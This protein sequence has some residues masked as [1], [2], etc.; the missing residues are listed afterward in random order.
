MKAA[1]LLYGNDQHY[2]DHLAPLASF[3]QIPLITTEE[4]IQ[5]QLSTYYPD[6]EGIFWDYLDVHFS[7]VNRFDTIFY[8]FTREHFEES[9]AF[10][11]DHFQKKI[12]TVWCPHGNSDKNNLGALQG[13][14]FLLTYGKKMDDLLK[15]KKIKKPKFS[16]GNYR[17]AYYQKH[18]KFYQD[19]LEKELS[20]LPR[21]NP[22]FLYAPTWQ[23][24]ENSSSFD[25]AFPYLL[26][27]LPDSVNLLIKLHPN[28]WAKYPFEVERAFYPYE[29]KKNLLLL[30]DFPAIYPILERVDAYIGDA[31]SIGYDFLRFNKPMFFLNNKRKTPLSEC[32]FT[33]AENDYPKIYSIIENKKNAD[34]PFVL[35]R[36][37]LYSYT[38]GKKILERDKLFT[39]IVQFYG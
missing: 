3:L 16:L 18:L 6:V 34:S 8:A 23:D 26:N 5:E 27:N 9:F 36:K 25:S 30:R 22:C 10:A 14:E 4:G 11:Q 38:F 35:K 12:R 31:S 21:D 28:T 19:L 17:F 24:Y 2:L 15:K 39:K 7:L 20:S 37:K 32:G 1:C 13:E 29:N 33:I